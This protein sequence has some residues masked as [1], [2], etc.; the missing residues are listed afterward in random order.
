MQELLKTQRISIAVL[1]VALLLLI[2][3][4][5]KKAP[6]NPFT[7]TAQEML[8]NMPDQEHVTS[9]TAH[10]LQ[11]DTNNYV[12][13]DLR[14][15]YDFEVK[16]IDNAINI[17]TAFLLDKENKALFSQYLKTNKTVV[18]YGQAERESI[19]PWMLLTEIGYTNTKILLGGF[20]CFS[21][22][23]TNCSLG[24]AKY[25]YDKISKSGAEKAKAASEKSAA[26]KTAKEKAAK[27][28]APVKKKKKTIPVKKKVKREA[29][30][31]C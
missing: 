6:K 8:K 28:P 30:G 21:G 1:V 25:D 5:V 2:G 27:V 24:Y 20:A 7:M 12:F 29:E 10:K 22:N 9:A 19:S 17:P 14:S 11:A 16:H 3:L 23:K 15:P 4:M 13:V 26:E 31:G 18:L